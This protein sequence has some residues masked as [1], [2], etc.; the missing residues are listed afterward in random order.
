MQILVRLDLYF[1]TKAIFICDLCKKTKTNTKTISILRNS[2]TLP[3]QGTV[4]R[5]WKDSNLNF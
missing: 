4:I 2:M 5:I 1:S 3:L